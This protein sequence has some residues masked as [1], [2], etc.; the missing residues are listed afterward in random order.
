MLPRFG[1]PWKKEDLPSL[2]SH[3]SVAPLGPFRKDDPP[4]SAL[5]SPT[6]CLDL[7]SSASHKEPRAAAEAHRTPPPRGPAVQG[8]RT[9]AVSPGESTGVVFL[10]RPPQLRLLA[11][12]QQERKQFPDP[13][14][15]SQATRPTAARPNKPHILNPTLQMGLK[16]FWASPIPRA[17]RPC[18]PDTPLNT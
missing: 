14:P 13:S 4:A 17:D 5:H 1:F 8:D 15:R 18:G 10:R 6:T 3:S 9:Q 12:A 2:A 7:A 11:P 16:P